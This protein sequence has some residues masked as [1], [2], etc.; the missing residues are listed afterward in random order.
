M[1]FYFKHMP[2]SLDCFLLLCHTLISL[3]P[4]FALIPHSLDYSSFMVNLGIMERKSFNFVPFQ[5]FSGHLRSF[6]CP[7]VLESA[8]QFLQESLLEC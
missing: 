5:D 1:Y 2:G 4:C 8:Y 7:S 6:M 3:N